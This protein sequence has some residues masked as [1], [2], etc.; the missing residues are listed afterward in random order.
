MGE[1][2]FAPRFERLSI[3]AGAK[4]RYRRRADPR[5]QPPAELPIALEYSR[6]GRCIL[7]STDWLR[8]VLRTARLN[9]AALCRDRRAGCNIC[10]RKPHKSQG[11]YVRTCPPTRYDQISPARRDSPAGGT[12]LCPL[13]PFQPRAR[14]QLELSVGQRYARDTRATN[15]GKVERKTAPTAADVEHATTGRYEKLRRKV[16]LLR[17]LGII[18]G[19]LGSLEIGAAVLTIGVEEQRVK[20]AVEVVMVRDIAPRSPARIELLSAA[21]EVSND[22]AQSRP[23]R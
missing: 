17:K 5:A 1:E 10:E 12:R 20:L 19:L 9:A 18:E 21:I 23:G 13:V 22:P 2:A 8:R 16:A 4:S 15:F 6:P 3:M 7:R 11:R 14:V